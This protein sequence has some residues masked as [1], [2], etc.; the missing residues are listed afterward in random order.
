MGRITRTKIDQGGT[1]VI[2]KA[3]DQDSGQVWAEKRYYHR[4]DLA[5]HELALLEQASGLDCV[6]ALAGAP[7]ANQH[8]VTL[9]L[10]YLDGPALD[11][12]LVDQNI[13]P[14]AKTQSLRQAGL[15][16]TQLHE[17]GITHADIKPDN[18]IVI[19]NGMKIIDL[20]LARSE[21][22]PWPYDDNSVVGTLEYISPEQANRESL[23][24][25]SDLFSFGAMVFEY[26]MDERPFGER[27]L[28]QFRRESYY[29]H[30]DE[31][32]GKIASYEDF[33]AYPEKVTRE[34]IMRRLCNNHLPADLVF[35]VGKVMAKRPEDRSIEPLLEALEQCP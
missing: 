18:F 24:P 3:E 25:A 20:G 10:E 31:I 7:K 32:R 4:R 33:S 15:A 19:N 16:I 21:K 13:S 14:K 5:F 8:A 30:A 28:E 22:K 23:F 2:Y 35:G 17:R 34:W 12:Y 29:R 26:L 6:V 27:P 11:R 9:C 1:A